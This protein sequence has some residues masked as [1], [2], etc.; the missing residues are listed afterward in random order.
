[1]L[2]YIGYVRKIADRI[3]KF[4]LFFLSCKGRNPKA[5]KFKIWFMI[6]DSLEDILFA[7]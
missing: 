4:R 6:F 7:R 1:M 5:G 3:L 2:Y